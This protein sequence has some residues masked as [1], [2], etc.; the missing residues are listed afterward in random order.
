[1]FH[2]LLAALPLGLELRKALRPGVALARARERVEWLKLARA[3]PT[4]PRDDLVRLGTGYGGYV[5]PAGI[6]RADWICYSAGLG[7]DVSFEVALIRRFGC[8]VHAFDPTPRSVSHVRE[9]ARREPRLRVYPFG[10]WSHDSCQRFYVPRDRDHVS[11]SIENLQRTSTYFVAPCRRVRSVM[12]ALGHDRLDLLKLDIEG[13]EHEV[14]ATLA[15]DRIEPTVLLVDIHSTP[16][17]SR[18]LASLRSLFARGYMPVD[19]F[20][21]DVTLLHESAF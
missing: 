18:A 21:S 5:V 8:S 12:D 10:L 2:T 6:P 15:E 7:E 14:L 11:H 4:A 3:V 1:M 13:A 16:S 17:F 20:R 9:I 19:V